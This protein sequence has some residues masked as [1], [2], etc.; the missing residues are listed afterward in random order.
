MFKDSERCGFGR[1]I[2][3]SDEAPK[4][5]IEKIE[6]VARKENL[7][8]T[9]GKNWGVKLEGQNGNLI[10]AVDVHQLTEKLVFPLFLADVLL[11]PLVDLLEKGGAF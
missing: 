9:K 3:V 1:E 4:K 10:V 5:I 2:F 7:T 8:P 6:E 11:F